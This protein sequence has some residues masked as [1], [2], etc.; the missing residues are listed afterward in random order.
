[1]RF[2]IFAILLAFPFLEI[3]VLIELSQRYGWW[4]LAYLLIIGFL[5]LQLI[6]AEKN[7]IAARMF[8]QL[9]AGGN[10]ISAMFST[11]RNMFAGV[12]LL[13]P[14]VI[15]DVIAVVLLFMPANKAASGS[16]SNKTGFQ[17]SAN[18]E[19]IEGEYTE[20]KEA[21]PKDNV[22]HLPKKD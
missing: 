15:S 20:V 5:G 2:I 14:G 4:V 19:A 1:M 11:A 21:K 9:A 6:R 3:A 17:A 18:D 16:T 12:L 8:Q 13:I 22:V 7:L 10:P